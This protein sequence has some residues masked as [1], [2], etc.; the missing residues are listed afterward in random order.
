MNQMIYYLNSQI[1]RVVSGSHFVHVCLGSSA[2]FTFR[3]KMV[4]IAE[5]INDEYLAKCKVT[6]TIHDPARGSGLAF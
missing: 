6:E 5:E 1:Y 2:Q 3:N 4:P